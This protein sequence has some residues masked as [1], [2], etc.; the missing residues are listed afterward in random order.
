MILLLLICADEWKLD[1]VHRKGGLDRVEGLILERTAEQVRIRCVRRRPGKPTVFWTDVVPA[2]E[3]RRVEELSPEER[4]KLEARLETLKKEREHLH[5][6]EQAI[7]KGTAPP[8]D[9][10]DLS[11]EDWPEEPRKR[12]MAYASSHFK[13]W[14]AGRPELAQL[15]AIYLEQVYAAYARIL[16]PREKGE[17]TT[18]LLMPMADYRA[19]LKARKLDLLAPAFYDPDRNRV[20]CGSDLSRLMDERDKVR[21]HHK[22][23]RGE[24][25]ER[26]AELMK[27]YKGKPPASLLSPLRDAEKRIDVSEGRN[28]DV[29]AR[30]RQRLF[31]RL[32]HESFHAYLGT[33]VYPGKGNAVPVW[34]NEGLAQVFESA[35]VE[36]GEMRIGHADPAKVAAVRELAKKKELPSLADLLRSTAKDFQA[37]H[38]SAKREADKHYLASWALAHWLAFDRRLLGTAKL[39]AYVAALGRD[40]D[41]ASAFRDL[42]GEPLPKAEEA[43]LAWLAK[44]R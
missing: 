31:A 39:D 41:P 17:P 43:W 13:L 7:G 18:I 22:K 36:A 14:C 33:C 38:A 1:V 3:I 26:R 44:L 5:G 20:V 10:V 9:M 16:P 19:M 23:L 6:L 28:A 42:V 8:A 32:Y 12:A 27:A 37:A 4:K 15:A 34:L 24:I 2:A 25:R 11:D 30:G 40:A 29:V 35:I 21:D